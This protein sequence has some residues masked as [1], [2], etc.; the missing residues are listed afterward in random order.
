MAA[1]AEGRRHLA[2]LLAIGLLSELVVSFW[3]VDGPRPVHELLLA[4]RPARYFGLLEYLHDWIRNC[5][6]A[7]TSASSWELLFLLEL[8]RLP[9]E[10]DQVDP[11]SLAG[12]VP[13]VRRV[14]QCDF[15][16][17]RTLRQPGF[18]GVDAL[19]EA[20]TK[21]SGT[22]NAPCV[23]KRFSVLQKSVAIVLIPMRLS[24][25]EKKGLA[26]KT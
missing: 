25:E 5:S 24:F 2:C 15:A 13:L 7:D 12:V 17:V 16:W 18:D 21:C 14:C 22:F 20:S 4:R 8:S 23:V 9:L 10:Y 3:P 1:V 19:V 26:E 6:V 11:S